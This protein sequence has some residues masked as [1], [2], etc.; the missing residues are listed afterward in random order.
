MGAEM[1]RKKGAKVGVMRLLVAWPF[2]EQRVRDLAEQVR[3]FVVPEINYGQMVLEVERAAAGRAAA[4]PCSHGG[5]G[6]HDPVRIC[7]T[8]LRAAQ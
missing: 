1:A 4:V 2:P 8:V 7:E 3:A 5:G 6:V